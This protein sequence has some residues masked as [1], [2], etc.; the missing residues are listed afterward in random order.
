MHALARWLT[1]LGISRNNYLVTECLDQDLVFVTLLVD[2]TNRLR[3]K[4]S[5]SNHSLP[6]SI[7][8]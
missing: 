5:G 4:C 3:S 8:N 2:I 6:V 7:Y 1:R